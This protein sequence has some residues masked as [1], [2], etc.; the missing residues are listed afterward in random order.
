MGEESTEGIPSPKCLTPISGV[1]T[2]VR[3]RVAPGASPSF[4][5][6]LLEKVLKETCT[7]HFPQKLTFV[8]SQLAGYHG[9]G[10]RL[11]S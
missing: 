6:A 10:R 8:N 2:H 1:V 3:S 11:A 7:I 9:F 4:I 5:R